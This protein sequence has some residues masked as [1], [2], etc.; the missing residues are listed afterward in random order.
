L[1]REREAKGFTQKQLGE[2][3]NLHPNTVAKME[4][5][6]QEP[7]WPVVLA[8]CQALGV[9]CTAFSGTAAAP[10]VANPEPTTT[11]KPPRKR[12]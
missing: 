8:I 12:K 3:I 9:P 4:R 2:A 11:K 6:E 5:G 10:T 7:P 1:K